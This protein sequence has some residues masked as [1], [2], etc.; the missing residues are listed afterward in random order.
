MT[1]AY[2]DVGAA[3]DDGVLV[4]EL[5]APDRVLVGGDTTLAFAGLH[6]P[7]WWYQGASVSN[8]AS[9]DRNG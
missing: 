8:S 1:S 6:V 2:P 9:N 7:H 5:A 4:E 3:G